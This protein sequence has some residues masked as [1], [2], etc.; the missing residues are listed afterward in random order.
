MK[1]PWFHA[2]VHSE[3]S[4]LDAISS[5]DR[6]VEKAATLKQPAMALTDHG[7]MSGTVQLYKAGKKHGIQVFPGVEAYLCAEPITEDKEAGKLQ[8]YHVGLLSLNFSGY[9]AIAA[10]SSK[11]HTR[12]RFNRFPRFDLNDLAELAG[13]EDIA[14]MTG[15]VSGLVI[16]TLLTRG[17]DAAKRIVEMY[18]RWFPHTFVEIQNHGNTWNSAYGEV[19]DE[20]I[21]EELVSIA[22]EVGVPVVA[23]QDSHYRDS[24]ER[25]AHNL[26]KRMVYGGEEGQNEFSGDSFHLASTQW[27]AEHHTEE[28]WD[29]ALEGAQ[30]LLSLNK[31]SLPALDGFKAHIPS[32]KKNPRK[33]ILNRVKKRLDE[34]EKAGQLVKPRRFYE[35]RVTHE[36]GIIDFLGMYGYFCLW[37]EV[38]EFCEEELIAI[39]ARGS[40]NGSLICY[41]LGITTVDPLQWNLLFERFLSK[42]RKKP[43]DIDMDVEDVRRDELVEFLRQRFGVVQIGTYGA[44]GS[45]D[46]DDK[47]SV[48]VSYNAYLRRKLGNNVFVPRFGRGIETIR[49]VQRINEEDYRGIRELSKSK[50]K[51]SYGVHAAG[52]LLNGDDQLIEDYVPTMLVASSGTIVTQ[53]TMD[54]V[55]EL[56]YIKKDILG[57]RTLTVMRRCQELIGRKNPRDFTWIPLDDK[58][59]VK[60]IR[61]GVPENGIFQFEGYAMAKGARVLGVRSTNDCILAGALFRPAC[62]ASGMTDLYIERRKDPSKRKGIVHPHPAFDEV[63]KDTFGIVL[64]QEQVLNIMRKLGLDY[65]GI[66]TFFKIVKDSGKGATARNI[67]RLAEVEE[68][69]AEICEKNGIEDPDAAWTYIE[70]YTQYGFNKAHSTGYGLRSYRV[71]FL[72]THHPLEYMTALLES[73]AGRQKEPVYVKEARRLGIRLLSPDVNISGPVWTLDRKKSA[74]RRGLSSIKGVGQSSAEQIAVNAPYEDIEEL[75]AKNNARA[76]TGGKQFLKDGSYSGALDALRKAGALSSLGIGRDD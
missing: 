48:L 19:T 68:R 58:A 55:E 37:T 69:W 23:A 65:E 32:T 5:V 45:R 38:V 49:D 22:A 66:N 8:R 13:N 51:R 72:K 43:P 28:A 59:T 14:L 57:Q 44:L 75:I 70:G 26:M 52:L 4:T 62:M 16:Q 47:G 24:K 42:D 76:V 50:V 39:E 12:P 56:G 7:N 71:A 63:L 67:E 9:Q 40:A 33:F 60:T 34:L 1:S 74:I 25:S 15:C 2:H 18:A 41:L 10:L 17:D 73:W 30:E 54:D 53:F 64:F 27:V 29:L 6:L 36:D 11:S 46:E 21:S 35:K 31:L 61:E 3:F 20:D